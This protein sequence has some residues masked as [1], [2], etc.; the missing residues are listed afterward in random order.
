MKPLSTT[1]KKQ[2]A[3]FENIS[4]KLHLREETIDGTDEIGLVLNYLHS[5]DLAIEAAV[6]AEMVEEIKKGS[7]VGWVCVLGT[8]RYSPIF[9]TKAE[10]TNYPNRPKGTE[11]V[12]AYGVSNDIL[13]LLTTSPSR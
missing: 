8:V 11:V 13:A 9:D 1:Q 5:R 3:L 7:W 10:A 2:D 6:R 4:K 12:R